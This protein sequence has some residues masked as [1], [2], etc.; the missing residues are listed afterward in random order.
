MV[1]LERSQC[2]ANSKSLEKKTSDKNTLS[3]RVTLEVI[4]GNI[5]LSWLAMKIEQSL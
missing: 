1:E 2:R 5:S 3:L 4:Q